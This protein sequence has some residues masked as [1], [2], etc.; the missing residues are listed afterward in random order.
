[1]SNQ[2][3]YCKVAIAP[4]RSE[5]KDA[6]EMV[7]QL[8]FGEVVT[9]LEHDE[10]WWHVQSYADNYA[11][12]VDPKQLRKLSKKEVSRWLDGLSYQHA[13]V[14]GLETPWGV[15]HIVKG[16]FLPY[17]VQEDFL[18]GNDAFRLLEVYQPMVHSDAF[19]LAEEYLNAPYLWGGKTPFGIDCSGLTQMVFRF[20]DINLPRDASQ[21]VDYGQAIDFAD[22]ESGDVAFFHNESGS[23]IH[24]GIIDGDTI[25]HASG[26]VRKDRFDQR[27][28]LHYSEEYHTHY[29]HSIRRML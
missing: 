27:G 6:S 1:M 3:A 13:L 15:Q 29:L 28:L 18:I 11:G 20:L 9:V 24:V 5:K 25:I 2:L 8:L 14:L 26:Q 7:T 21:Q 22:R 4:V 19:K 17:G 12:W 10:K 16:S 23:V